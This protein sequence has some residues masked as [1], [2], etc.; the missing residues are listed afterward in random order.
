[1]KEEVG[2]GESEG[3]CKGRLVINNRK[4]THIRTIKNRTGQG[5]DIRGT[6]GLWNRLLG[7]LDV[8]VAAS[9]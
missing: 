5:G 7:G 6:A 3:K 8:S 4:R 9:H 1:M 2:G